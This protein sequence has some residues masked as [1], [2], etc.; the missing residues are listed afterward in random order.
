MNGSNYKYFKCLE[1]SAFDHYHVGKVLNIKNDEMSNFMF[2][3]RLKHF[4]SE[5]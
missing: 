4:S 1:S 3:F 2:D 5:H